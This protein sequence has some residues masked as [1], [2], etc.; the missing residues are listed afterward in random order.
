MMPNLLGNMD[1]ALA[2]ATADQFAKENIRVE[3][4]AKV[5]SVGDRDGAKIVTYEKD[6]TEGSVSAEYVLVSAGR[7]AN[8]A[9]LGC[10]EVGI[11]MERGFIQV[12]SRMRTSVP[13]IYAAG[14]IT[15]QGMLAHTAFEGGTVAVEN[16]AGKDRELDLKAVP[17]VVFVDQE[18]ASVGMTEEDRKGLMPT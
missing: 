4:G 11:R 9:G 2:D 18:V 8:S 13:G 5:K 12:D 1:K 7:K 10:E 15:G 17:K 6:G 14:D 3:L 16:I